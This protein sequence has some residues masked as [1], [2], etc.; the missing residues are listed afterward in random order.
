[1]TLTSALQITLSTYSIFLSTT[2]DSDST[3][4]ALGSSP[5]DDLSPPLPDR[6]SPELLDVLLDRLLL[7]SITLLYR[8]PLFPLFPLLDRPPLPERPLLWK[9]LLGSDKKLRILDENR[10]F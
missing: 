1:M 9:L 4:V 5:L 6:K 2:K 8:L 7:M 10:L 3:V